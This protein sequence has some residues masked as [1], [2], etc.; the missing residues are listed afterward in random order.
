M[1]QGG[2]G[3]KAGQN[4]TLVTRKPQ[5]PLVG[6]IREPST[7]VAEAPFGYGGLRLPEPVRC[8]LWFKDLSP[9]EPEKPACS[10]K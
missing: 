6:C 2:L 9:N 4:S 7:L 10:R 1:L 3:S 5:S 8:G